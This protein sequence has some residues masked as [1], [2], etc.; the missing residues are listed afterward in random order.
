MNRAIPQKASERFRVDRFGS[1]R[2]VAIFGHESE[3][4]EVL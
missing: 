1:V 4:R 2:L 3:A